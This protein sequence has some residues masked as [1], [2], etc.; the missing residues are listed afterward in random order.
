M[1]QAGTSLRSIPEYYENGKI[2]WLKTGEIKKE[3]IYRTSE[4]ITEKGL[5]NSS[6][7]IIPKNSVLVAMYGDGDTAGHAAINKIDLATNQACCNLIIDFKKAD[8]RFIYFFLKGSYDHLINLKLGGSQQNLN[9]ATIRN[10]DIPLPEKSIQQKIAA[11][12]SAYDDLIENNNRRIAILEKMAEEI[13]KDWF[14]RMRFPGYEKAEFEKG[15]PKE[16]K[17]KKIG[18]ICFVGRGS[19]PR[20]IND[21]AY[22][23]NGS[24]PW[25][26]IADATNSKMFILDTKECVNEFGASFSRKLSAGGLIIA[27]SGTLGFCIFLGVEGCIHDGWIYTSNYKKNIRPAFLFYVINDFRR[28][29]NNLSYGAAIQ[30]I[31]TNIIRN[32]SVFVP[33]EEL[34]DRF[35]ISVEPIHKLILNKILKSKTLKQTRDRL[36]TRLIS[37]K[38]TVADLDIRFPRSMKEESDAELHP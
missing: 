31:N 35:Y 32:L 16:W 21:K 36:L 23:E 11:I 10:I 34:L 15:I 25:I 1:Y 18:N 26:K 6:A 38:L 20:P 14:V 24:I 4:S 5:K 19:S 9:A 29:L 2:P 12:L 8:Y 33:S 27:T 28:H 30:N 17:I 7:K 3:Y 37:G 13:Y 22:F